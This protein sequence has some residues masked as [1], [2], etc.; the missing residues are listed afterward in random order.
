MA[1]SLPIYF[2]RKEN[3]MEIKNYG[4][5]PKETKEVERAKEITQVAKSKGTRR[6][7]KFISNVIS[8]E[9]GDVK[10]YIVM[11]V[12]IPAVKKTIVDIVENGIEML[13]GTSGRSTSSRSKGSRVSYSSYYDDDRRSSRTG[14]RYDSG[15]DY[16][17]IIFDTRG[18]AEVVLDSMFEVLDRYKVV[19]IADYYDLC[20]ERCPHTANRYGWTDLSN[21]SVVRIRDGYTIRLPR[22]LAID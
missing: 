14:R 1:G 7:N 12:L 20:G 8:E 19:T 10:N 3:R 21:A 9:A 5:S 11:D 4:E 2:S 18:D 6:R 15:F 13:M 17:D 22:A 16:D